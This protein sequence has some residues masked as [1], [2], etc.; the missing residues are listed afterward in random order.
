[1]SHISPSLPDEVWSV[2][3][4]M[5]QGHRHPFYVEAQAMAA[6]RAAMGAAQQPPKPTDGISDG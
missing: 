6:F 5:L 4:S 3:I 1:M 2:L